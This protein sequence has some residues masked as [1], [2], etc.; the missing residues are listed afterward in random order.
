MEFDDMRLAPAAPPRFNRSLLE[1]QSTFKKV[2]EESVKPIDFA[3]LAAGIEPGDGDDMG[4]DMSD[5]SGETG[6]S[7]GGEGSA[8]ENAASALGG[9]LG[10]DADEMSGEEMSGAKPAVA[11]PNN[12][13]G[14]P[15]QGVEVARKSAMDHAMEA[16]RNQ[17][18]DMPMPGNTTVRAQIGNDTLAA[19]VRFTD[20][21]IVAANWVD[22]DTLEVELEIN[23]ADAAKAFSGT[24][25]SLDFGPVGATEGVVR[26]KGTGVIPK[27]LRTGNVA[28][29]GERARQA[30]EGLGI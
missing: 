14:R 8:L 25:D 18:L 3:A 1:D 13:A 24:F 10:G 6:D 21:R 17:I 28:G 15:D 9:L 7:D 20:A 2:S 23:Y 19:T 22:A 12:P 16:I 29:P 5:E 4:D 26:A 27:G 11:I 30:G